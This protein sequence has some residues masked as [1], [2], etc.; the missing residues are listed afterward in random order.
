MRDTLEV[1]KCRSVLLI[2]LPGESFIGMDTC[3]ERRRKGGRIAFSVH[4]R[5]GT[6]GK[7]KI[8]DEEMREKGLVSYDWM[9]E[10]VEGGLQPDMRNQG[11][12]WIK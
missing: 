11:H 10:K 1:P 5:K 9:A 6:D 7:G 3:G 4:P 12:L 8:L 2:K